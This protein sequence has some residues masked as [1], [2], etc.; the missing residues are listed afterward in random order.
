MSITFANLSIAHEH[1]HYNQS[2]H[3]LTLF[4][5]QNSFKFNGISHIM[6]S[7]RFRAISFSKKRAL[8]FF[9]AIELLT[10]RKCIAS[11]SNQNVQAW[12]IRKGMLVGCK[13]TLRSSAKDNF[14]NLL[15]FS[16]PRIEKFSPPTG[17]IATNLLKYSQTEKR[18]QRPLISVNSTFVITIS[19][20]VLFYPIEF[21][22]GLHPDV[23]QIVVN[24]R[25][26]SSS[27]EERYF[28]LRQAKI[29]LS[30]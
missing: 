2:L 24:F 9:L 29:P 25:F 18:S 5:K 22:L 7:F 1:N 30:A 20:L 27:I 21:S 26:S 19:E 10:Q 6:V 11:L 28:F 15:A 3:Q 14:I 12:K 23:R 16:F 17:V 13:V 4:P 8:A